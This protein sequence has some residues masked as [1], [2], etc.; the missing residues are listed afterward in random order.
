MYLYGEMESHSYYNNRVNFRVTRRIDNPPDLGNR[1]GVFHGQHRHTQG[2]PNREEQFRTPPC[3]S[4][5]TLEH[6]MV[7]VT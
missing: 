5:S 7:R 2:F 3:E 4:I 6:P 1:R